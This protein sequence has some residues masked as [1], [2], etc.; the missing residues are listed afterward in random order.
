MDPP[1]IEIHAHHEFDVEQRHCCLPSFPF[2]WSRVG[3]R[4]GRNKDPMRSC[5]RDLVQTSLTNWDQ[6]Y[7]HG[8][9][10]NISYIEREP[11]CIAETSCMERG[12]HQHLPGRSPDLKWVINKLLHSCT[13]IYIYIYMCFKF[14]AHTISLLNFCVIRSF[15]SGLLVRLG[16]LLAR[17]IWFVP[18][19]YIE[20][21]SSKKTSISNSKFQK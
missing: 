13:C 12:C 1:Y 10:A 16:L 15:R 4:L 18:E 5:L 21:M 14:L 19:K 6:D 11:S 7:F 3:N 20:L 17:H 8:Q 2:S 9:I